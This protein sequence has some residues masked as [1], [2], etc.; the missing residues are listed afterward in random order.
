MTAP[1]LAERRAE[2]PRSLPKTPERAWKALGWF[3]AVLTVIGLAQ[4]AV[5][6]YPWGWGSREWEF[7]ASAQILGALPLPTMGLAGMLAAAVARGNRGGLLGLSLAFGV[8]A[9][10]VLVLLVMFWLVV[11]IALGNT[12]AAGQP[13]IRQTIARATISGVGF[14]LL[15]FGAAVFGIVRVRRTLERR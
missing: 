10:V 2:T 7:A 15:Y 9:V 5:Y 3:G 11:P 4:A 14:G 12:A 13:V 6:L 8:L 1:I